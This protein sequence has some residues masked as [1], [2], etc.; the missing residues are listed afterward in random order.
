M[1][2]RKRSG[3]LKSELRKQLG[4]ADRRRRAREIETGRAD[5]EDEIRIFAHL[6]D[7]L[8]IGLGGD[9]MQGR[10]LGDGMPDRVV[11]GAGR[12]LAAMDMRDRNIQQRG[13][14]RGRQDFVAVAEH[15]KQVG[16]E[17]RQRIREA[18]KPDAGAARHRLGAVVVELEVDLGRDRKAV[19]FDRAPGL[20]EFRHQMHAAGDHAEIDVISGLEAR[21]DAPQQSVIRPRTGD[22]GDAARMRHVC[23][24]HGEA[25]SMPCSIT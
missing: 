25:S 23:L 4:A 5:I 16:R 13:G 18:G 17:L 10:H 2:S 11:E 22:D 7:A 8:P 1:I 19:G 12:D 15:D 24:R 9:E 14:D 3:P 21:K 20:A 6:D